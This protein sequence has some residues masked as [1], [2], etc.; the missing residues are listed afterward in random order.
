M[1]AQLIAQAVRRGERTA[2]SVTEEALAAVAARDPEIH[3]FVDIQSDQALS[4]AASV[5]AAVADGKDPG[6]LAGCRSRSKT[7]C[8]SEVR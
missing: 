7:T 3:A 2:V 8:A 5:D 1:S 6:I 4:H